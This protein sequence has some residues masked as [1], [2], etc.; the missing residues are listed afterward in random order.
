MPSP[1][2]FFFFFYQNK[3]KM[4]R[5]FWNKRICKNICEVF[6]MVSVKTVFFLSIKAF[7]SFKIIHFRPF[8][9]FMQKN[10]RV[11]S[12]CPLTAVHKFKMKRKGHIVQMGGG[13]SNLV[14]SLW[15]YD[16]SHIKFRR[17]GNGVT[18]GIRDLSSTPPTPALHLS[19]PRVSYLD[20]GKGE[21]SRIWMRI[22][23]IG[24]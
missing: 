8:L 19:W 13:H 18:K 4:F 14:L 17:N 2:T 6:A 10:V 24:V 7:I 5:M 15:R 20:R 11:K 21:L 9:N 12:L 23:S 16:E 1:I 3:E 22:C